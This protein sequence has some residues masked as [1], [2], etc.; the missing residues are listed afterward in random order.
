MQG[1][2]IV[3]VRHGESMAQERGVVGGHKGCTGLSDRGRAQVGALRDRW[4]AVDELG[5]DVVLYASVMRRA[6]ETAEILAPVLG[7]PVISE[8]CAFCEHH[9]GEGDG[10]PWAEFDERYPHPGDD[11]HPDLRRDP[12][13]ETWNE[14]AA[15][16][17]AGVDRLVADHPGRTVVVA[18]HGGVIVQTMIRSLR[19]D[20][21]ATGQRAWFGPDNASITE[22]RCGPNPYARRSGEWQ[23]VRFND[24]AHLAATGL[25][26]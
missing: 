25:G 16:V 1:T 26:R 11:W 18:C 15:R 7:D 13:S 4:K 8:D 5:G 20:V 9:P 10:L 21:D 17:R 19:I 24:H 12:G 14:M 6:V 2:R 3:M 23:L 22:W